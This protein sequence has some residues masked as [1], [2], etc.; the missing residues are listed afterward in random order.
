MTPAADWSPA[1]H[2][3]AVDALASLGG[4]DRVLI[5]CDDGCV[6]CQ[7]IMPDFAAALRAAGIGDDRVVQ[8]AVERLPEGRK[9]GPL[10]EEYGVERI[11]TIVV[12]RGEAKIA[13]FVESEP[14]PA[15]VYLADRLG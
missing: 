12:E 5:W 11:P 15:A 8:H 13:R 9:R 7:S 2:R 4:A 14:V 10:V 6:D 3:E 1:A